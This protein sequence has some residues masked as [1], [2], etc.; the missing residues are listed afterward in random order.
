MEQGMQIGPHDWQ[1]AD[2][3][4]S[5]RWNGG[6]DAGTL[7]AEANTDWFNDPAGGQP[8]SNAPLLLTAVQG[9]FQLSVRAEAE[10]RSTYDAA[11]LF[12]Y[13]N[14]TTWAKLAL[15]LS[16]DGAHTIVTVVTRGVSDDAN[17]PPVTTPGMAWLRVSRMGSVYAFHH[18]PD[19]QR[20]ALTRLFTIGE[21]GEHRV[22]LSVQ[23]PLGTGL[24]VHFDHLA[25]RPTTLADPRDGS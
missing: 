3:S 9:D 24:T 8:T 4:T 21:V 5:S 19:G 6:D 7:A 14:D 13:G 17:G 11:A 2:G 1:N 15:E 23:S 22:G 18:S 16:P 25:I 12:V 10:L 20:W